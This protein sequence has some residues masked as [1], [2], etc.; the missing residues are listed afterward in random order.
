MLQGQELPWLSSSICTV[1]PTKPAEA[2]AAFPKNDR[3]DDETAVGDFLA[4]VF[5]TPLLVDRVLP[6]SVI[7][8][9][10]PEAHGAQRTTDVSAVETFIGTDESGIEVLI[11]RRGVLVSLMI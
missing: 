8:M 2:A 5:L 11:E 7:D 9:L 10:N 4:D 1:D 3:R 6:A